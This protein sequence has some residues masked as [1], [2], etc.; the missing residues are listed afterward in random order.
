MDA[1]SVGN[2]DASFRKMS[3]DVIW[4]DQRTNARAGTYRGKDAVRDHRPSRVGRLLGLD[5]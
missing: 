5:R 1:F 3:D 4:F 2:L